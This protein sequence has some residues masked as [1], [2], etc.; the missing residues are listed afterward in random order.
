M[1]LEVMQHCLTSIA[2]DA[3]SD[4]NEKLGTSLPSQYHPMLATLEYE[5]MKPHEW[6]AKSEY[7][8][9]SSKKVSGSYLP[10]VVKVRQT[11]EVVR[12]GHGGCRHVDWQPGLRHTTATSSTRTKRLLQTLL[13]YLQHLWKNAKDQCQHL[14]DFLQDSW[15][16][17]IGGCVTALLLLF[18]ETVLLRGFEDH[19]IDAWP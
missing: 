7:N 6:I 9:E 3:D 15:I 13:G 19:Q 18:A 4:S 17:E 1:S 2:M 10:Y 8:V 16:L 12:H 11:P 5:D 14:I